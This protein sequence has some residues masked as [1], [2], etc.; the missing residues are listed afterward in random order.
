MEITNKSYLVPNYSKN[1]TVSA[2]TT[3]IDYTFLE[4]T[5]EIVSEDFLNGVPVAEFNYNSLEEE[6]IAEVTVEYHLKPDS[7]DKVTLIFTKD[8]LVTASFKC[9]KSVAAGI[10][11]SEKIFVLNEKTPVKDN[12]IFDEKYNIILPPSSHE[13]PLMK[14]FLSDEG[15]PSFIYEP[16]S[17]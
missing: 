6:Q 5:Q 4:N 10:L 8:N 7:P 15:V 12:W 9:P 3:I 2:S 17:T 11:N 16:R 13:R 14:H 1:E